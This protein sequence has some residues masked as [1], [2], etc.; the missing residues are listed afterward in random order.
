M[1]RIIN[2][3]KSVAWNLG[4]EAV[5]SWR[6]FSH[7]NAFAP[8]LR[9]IH[10]PK[11]GPRGPG[12][13]GAR[14][15]PSLAANLRDADTAQ[16]AL[17]LEQRAATSN[18]EKIQVA[19]DKRREA[20]SLP[21]QM[22][23]SSLQALHEVCRMNRT[24]L[25]ALIEA[26]RAAEDQAKTWDSFTKGIFT[27]V[28]NV[29][30]AVDKVDGGATEK[31]LDGKD[32]TIPKG[33]AELR[34]VL[35]GADGAGDI[36]SLL[37]TLQHDN[38]VTKLLDEQ[39]TAIEKLT[40]EQEKVTAALSKIAETAGN[41][42]RHKSDNEKLWYDDQSA[43]ADPNV[44]FA[45]QSGH[46]PPATSIAKHLRVGLGRMAPVLGHQSR[47]GTSVGAYQ[48]P[49]ATTK[50]SPVPVVSRQPTVKEYPRDSCETWR[51]SNMRPRIAEPSNAAGCRFLPPVTQ[52][53]F[54]IPVDTKRSFQNQPLSSISA[55]CSRYP[56][57]KIGT[58]QK[59]KHETFCLGDD[60]GGNVQ[61][62]SL[63][64]E[65]E[66]EVDYYCLGKDHPDYPK[67]VRVLEQLR[68]AA[69]SKKPFHYMPSDGS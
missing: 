60:R 15:G 41:V 11:L 18:L 37:G 31:E 63:R 36:K 19:I 30:E 48:Q 22:F 52:K 42:A 40:T 55:N 25:D 47:D 49:A 57:S 7:I 3:K 54:T 16:A 33:F 53:S 29:A 56:T 20:A 32:G 1:N 5:D 9:V 24:Q 59:R 23:T 39:K 50:S 4:S 8:T 14:T 46:R 58:G 12:V 64:A 66:V 43:D 26:H 38:T 28:K 69:K 34:K 2:N 21:A 51:S 68:D 61:M 67:E 65:K 44:V 6:L 45:W 27:E 17:E 10:L 35:K 62:A 13:F